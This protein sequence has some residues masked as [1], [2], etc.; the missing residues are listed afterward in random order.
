[1]TARFSLF[2]WSRLQQERNFVF[3]VGPGGLTPAAGS[4]VTPLSLNHLR[5]LCGR[6]LGRKL[7]A[8]LIG[9]SLKYQCQKG[10]SRSCVLFQISAALSLGHTIVQTGSPAAPLKPAPQKEN[11]PRGHSLKS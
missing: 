2:W 4:S 3:A 10:R 11:R 7:K 8:D 6:C 5:R 9:L 1:M